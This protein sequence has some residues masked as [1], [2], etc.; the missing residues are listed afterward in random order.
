MLNCSP[1]ANDQTVMARVCLIIIFLLSTP[2]SFGQ[3]YSTTSSLDLVIGG[4]LYSRSFYGALNAFDSYSICSPVQFMGIAHSGR[5]HLTRGKDFDGHFS[6][7]QILPKRIHLNDTVH[8]VLSGF[9]FGF[10]YGK[11]LFKASKVIDA[12]VGIGFNTGRLKLNDKVSV[13]RKNPYFAPKLSLQP[14]IN[15]NKIAISI[16]IEYEYDISRSNWFYRSNRSNRYVDV[17]SFNQTSLT[18]FASIGYIFP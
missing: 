5:M 14:K 16:R 11:D 9:V 3:K 6:Y 7:C 18:C 8:P 2:R 10:N 15:L 4:K 13:N 17:K 12:I 1:I